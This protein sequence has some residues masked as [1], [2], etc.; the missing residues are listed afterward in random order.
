MN[1]GIYILNW[2]NCDY[3]YYGSSINLQ[4]RKK[5]HYNKLRNGNHFN[6]ILLKVYKKHGLPNFSIVENC[7]KSDLYNMELKYLLKSKGDKNNINIL[8]S[9]DGAGRCFSEESKRKISESLRNRIFS[10]VH[11]LNLKLCNAGIN[12]PRY[13]K[14]V[15]KETR[16]KLSNAQKREKNNSARKVINI[17]TGKIYLCA[18]CITDEDKSI[19]YYT[20]IGKLSGRRKNN[21]PYRY[22]LDGAG[23]SFAETQK[24]PAVKQKVIKH[25]TKTTHCLTNMNEL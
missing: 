10:D 23:S 21:T 11:I 19:N 14:P 12:N 22:I 15:L 20:L 5:Q 1:T 25:I 18:K 9:P 17:S 7:D 4:R 16:E 6:H 13:G 8:Y 24:S 3:Y 2:D